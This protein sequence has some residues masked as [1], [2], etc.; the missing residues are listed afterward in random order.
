M[1]NV[2]ILGGSSDLGTALARK[3]AASN[4]SVSIA[5]R[6]LEEMKLVA[7]DIHIRYGVNAEAY[8]FDARNFSSHEQFYASLSPKPDISILVFGFMGDPE[9]ALNDW[10]DTLKVI[11]TN[12]TGAVSIANIIAREYALKAT[13]TIIGISSVAGDRG[14][15]SNFIYGSAKAA[16]TAYLSGLRNRMFKSGVHIITVKPGFMY[17]RMTENLP[18]PA[19]L[20]AKTDQVAHSVFEAGKNGKNILYTKGLWKYIML[21]IKN[22]PEFIFKKLS[23]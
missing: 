17:T 9:K 20:T 15:G 21:I 18:L 3:Y 19:L 7:S 13:G 10:D 11:E 5:G 12:F 22:I 23:L 8:Q 2:L 14:R 6:N 1:Q 4:Y 16:F